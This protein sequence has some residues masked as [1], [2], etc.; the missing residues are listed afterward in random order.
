[1]AGYDTFRFAESEN[2]ICVKGRFPDK[3]GDD[4]ND[5]E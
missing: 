5:K 1:M 4:V 2:R 3:K